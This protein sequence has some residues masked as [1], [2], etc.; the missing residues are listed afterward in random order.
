MTMAKKAPGRSSSNDDD[1]SDKKSTAKS[2]NDSK[3]KG[4]SLPKTVITK[5]SSSPAKTT[6]PFASPPSPAMA[7]FATS[8][9]MSMSST[10]TATSVPGSISFDFL[11]LSHRCIVVK[12]LLFKSGLNTL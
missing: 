11:G 2:S 9:A 12:T 1:D 10:N 7:V 5:K 6:H 4:K 3:S 8:P